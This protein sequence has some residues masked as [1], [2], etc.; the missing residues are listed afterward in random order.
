[1]NAVSVLVMSLLSSVNPSEK[2]E[3][4]KNL[5]QQFM[6]IS[7]ELEMLED[8][9]TDYK[10]KLNTISLKYD[11]LIQDYVFE[12]IPQHFKNNI[13][14]IYYDAN[15]YVSVQ[16]NSTCGDMKKR[17]SRENNVNVGNISELV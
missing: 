10:N 14:K 9:D 8:T 4:S 11:N 3:S 17:N 16:L 6:L 13:A 1:M 5:S 2:F 15:R 12:E 7:Q